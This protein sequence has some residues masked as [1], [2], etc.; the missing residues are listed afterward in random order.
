MA[1]LGF[2]QVLVHPS[3]RY[4]GKASLTNASRLHPTRHPVDDI[5]N[6]GGDDGLNDDIGTKRQTQYV[7]FW[8]IIYCLLPKT[9]NLSGCTRSRSQSCPPIWPD[10]FAGH[11]YHQQ[12]GC[13]AG[14][15]D[16]RNWNR[17]VRIIFTT[18]IVRSLQ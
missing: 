6:S 13:G 8:L 5:Q 17:H 11:I 16:R 9:H 15:S 7:W 18:T 1:K 2:D 3:S 12:R 10:R 14:K 4:R